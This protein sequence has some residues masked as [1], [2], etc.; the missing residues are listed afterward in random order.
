M[1]EFEI[2]RIKTGGFFSPKI[3]LMYQIKFES[4]DPGI[5]T[6]SINL[7][8]AEGNAL[9]RLEYTINNGVAQIGTF[10]INEWITDL[11]AERLLAK[12]IYH[13]RKRKVAQI[14]VEL[15]HT[16]NTAHKKLLLF[17]SKGFSV[18]SGGNITGYQQYFL[19]KQ[20]K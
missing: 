7:F 17:K 12:F 14:T 20:M 2:E 10:T 8:D 19:K 16:D 13:M 11:Y 18:E 3:K 1:A 4:T 15:Y 6:K 5:E 9:G